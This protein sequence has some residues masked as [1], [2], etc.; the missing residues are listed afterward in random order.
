[1]KAYAFCSL[2]KEHYKKINRME[3]F[4]ATAPKSLSSH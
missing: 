3:T 2:K 4:K 1:M